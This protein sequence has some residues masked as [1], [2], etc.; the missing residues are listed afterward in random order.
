MANRGGVVGPIELGDSAADP[1]DFLPVA[2]AIGPAKALPGWLTFKAPT[3]YVPASL[4]YTVTGRGLTIRFVGAYA[5]Y[6]RI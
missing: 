3:S 6:P 4:S 1:W 2:A 5:V